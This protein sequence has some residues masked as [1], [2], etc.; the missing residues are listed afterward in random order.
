MQ[1]T[2][3]RVI[4]GI[5]AVAIVVIGFVALSGGDDDNDSTTQTTATTATTGDTSTGKGDEGPGKIDKGD[6]AD[7]GGGEPVS[8]VPVIKLVGGQPAGGVAEL[9]FNSGD[10]I[11]FDVESDT[12]APIHFHGYDI[13]QEVKAGG[14][15]KFSVPADIEGIFEVEVESTAVPIAEITVNP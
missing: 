2:A 10:T 5:V 11:A 6:K 12:D 15:S 9:S 4:T 1:S 14:T 7:K 13:E 3:A 8:D